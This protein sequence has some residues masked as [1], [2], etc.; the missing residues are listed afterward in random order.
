MPLQMASGKL[1]RSDP[2]RTNELRGILYTNLDLPE[3]LQTAAGRLVPTSNLKER[4][5]VYELREHMEQPP[6]AGV[7]VSRGIDPYL[8]D[9]SAVT[10]FAL[11]VVCTPDPD[12][13]RR[14]LVGPP[15]PTTGAM[16]RRFASTTFS[17]PVYCK[18]PQAKR[19]ADFVGQLIGL[20][21]TV[22][23]DA[24]RAIRTYVTGMYRLGDDPNAAY[25]LLL[26]SPEPLLR[27]FDAEELTWDDYPA[28]RRGRIDRALRNADETTRREVQE[29]LV[30]LDRKAVARRLR[31]FVDAHLDGSFFREE[32]SGVASPV[33]R[34]ELQRCLGHAYRLR[35]SY[36]HASKRLPRELTLGP[37]P[38]A[39]TIRVVDRGTILTF[40]GLGRL[41]RHVIRQFI[42][43]Q[44]SVP[45]EPCDYSG[46]EPG[47]IRGE[48]APEYWLHRPGKFTAKDGQKRLFAFCG[49]LAAAMRAGE[50]AKIS[51]MRDLLREA[52]SR[53]AGMRRE[54]RLP[55][56]ALHCLF[57]LVVPADDRIDDSDIM[58]FY[59]EDL[60]LPTIEAMLL[61][62]LIQRVP[63]WPLTDHERAL[64]AYLGGNRRNE[65]IRMDKLLEAGLTLELAERYRADGDT[66]KARS[67]I[68]LA[69]ENHP[70]NQPLMRLE[71]EFDPSVHI[72][73]REVMG[74]PSDSGGNGDGA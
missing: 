69:L 34:S 72:E 2:A 57:N 74:L 19:F 14:L 40:E 68:S 7:L 9:F 33:G 29:A 4:E 63:S 1:F 46:E 27:H 56:V 26:S 15:S 51:D 3:P 65:G 38:R 17:E 47:V 73:W 22:F 37:A 36:L 16:P 62:L 18:P 44:E 30:W 41:V 55:F 67:L 5:L 28:N 61:E 35:S 50:P 64:D 39:E 60:A 12:L 71:Q 23:L 58:R 10:A 42:S 53:L 43:R 52:G 45:H 24:M 59:E 49:Q 66:D 11:N 6:E 48:F 13:K 31:L 20:R 25:T 70:G 8:S 54:D 21:R 32:A